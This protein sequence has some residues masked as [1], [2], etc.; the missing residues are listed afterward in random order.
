MILRIKFFTKK[1]IKSAYVIAVGLSGLGFLIRLATRR[2]KRLAILMYHK[3][4]QDPGESYYCVTKSNFERQVK[5][6]KSA[7]D[8]VSISDVRDYVTGKAEL[9]KNS[10]CITFDDGYGDIYTQVLELAKKNGIPIAVGLV[11]DYVDKD[12]EFSWDKMF[13]LKDRKLLNWAQIRELLAAQAAFGSHSATHANLA[14]LNDNELRYETVDSRRAIET[15]TG[16]VAFFFIYP[17]G[18]SANIDLR[19]TEAVRKAGYAVALTSIWGWV[20]RDSDP[21]MLRRINVD[22]SDTMLTFKAKLSGVFDILGIFD[23]CP[24]E[25]ARRI[26]TNIFK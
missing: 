16:R 14:S 24:Y 22:G 17:F 7:F 13:K 15:M 11:S 10:C 12:K 4:T 5:Y 9:D 18:A 21:Y 20:R 26:I 2:R 1:V 23:S 19:V 8:I 6:L 25:F 3:V